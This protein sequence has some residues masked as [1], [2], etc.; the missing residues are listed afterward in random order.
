M[1]MSAAK[2]LVKIKDA[3]VPLFFVPRCASC[4]EVL[5][6][7]KTALCDKC[8]EIYELESKY[9]CQKCGRSHRYCVCKIPGDG[10]SYPLVHL[11][12]YDIKRDAVSKSI[13]LNLKDTKFTGA[14]DFFATELYDTVNARYPRLFDS[15]RVIVTYVPRSKKARQRAGH[16]QSF[17]I[18]RR[19]SAISGAPVVKIFKNSSK[20]QQKQLNG[21]E[22]KKNA[23]ESYRLV[24][25]EIRLTGKTV[26]L[27]DDI[28]TTGST[29][30]ACAALA[31]KAKAKAVIP[32][33]LARAET[34]KSVKEKD[35]L[36]YGEDEYG[37]WN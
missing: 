24:S 18:A 13:I 20:K 5:P 37:N 3:V 21:A 30:C 10:K 28:T 32:L 9:L 4:L 36:I 12:A 26:L 35:Y 23:N 31:Q 29:L 8:K 16:D 19:L 22:R 7:A 1:S 2:L 27:V 14:F 15:G 17:E 11:S 34:G 6:S 25:E 33:V